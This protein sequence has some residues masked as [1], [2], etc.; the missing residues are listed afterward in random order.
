MASNKFQTKFDPSRLKVKGGKLSVAKGKSIPIPR[1]L[2]K[3]VISLLKRFFLY[4]N[5]FG[6]IPGIEGMTNMGPEMEK[7]GKNVRKSS[8]GNI[9]GIA[10]MRRMGMI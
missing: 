6:D 5:I 9:Q 1:G 10:G 7:S 2:G 3:D 8:P 4:K